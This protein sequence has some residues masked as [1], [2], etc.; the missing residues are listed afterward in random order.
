L[1]R[2]VAGTGGEALLAQDTDRRIGVLLA[3]LGT[4]DAPTP[5]ALRR[6]LRQFLSDPRVVERNRVLWWFIL[7]LLVLPR[8]PRRSA[9]LYQRV[10]TP[11]GSPL[12]LISRSQ[13]RGLEA[14]L[15]RQEPDRFKVALGMRYGSPSIESAVRELIDWGADRLLLF[16]AYPQYA[17]PTTASTYDEVFRLLSMRRF[18]PTLRVVPPYYAHTAY[19]EALAESVR[20][21]MSSRSRPP[22]KILVSFHGIPQSFVDSGD[23][24]ASHCEATARALATCAGWET[25]TYVLS[26]QSRAGREPWLLPNTDETLVELARTGAR[27]VMVICPGFVAD[28]LETIDEIG[29]VAREQFRAAGGETLQLVEGLNSRPRWIAAMTEIALEQV[30]GWR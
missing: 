26:Y 13:A 9:A 2:F 15:N 30:Q 21:A 5:A 10:W 25:G 7:R 17:G 11:T 27:H 14:A 20:D 16:P 1:S 29:Y 4:P 6:Y 23:P 8:K 12:L 22:E 19:I 18:V 24:Y 28:C 3:Q